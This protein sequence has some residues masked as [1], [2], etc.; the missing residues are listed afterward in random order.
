M[1]RLVLGIGLELEVERRRLRGGNRKRLREPL[2][3]DTVR[4]TSDESRL[5]ISS[6]TSSAFISEDW[7]RS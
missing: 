4:V 7:N 2:S 3:E 1:R 6:G 5:R